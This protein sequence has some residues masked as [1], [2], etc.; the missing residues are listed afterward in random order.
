VPGSAR[1]CAGTAEGIC[2]RGGDWTCRAFDHRTGLGS[3][4]GQDFRTPNGLKRWQLDQKGSRRMKP[5]RQPLPIRRPWW[6]ATLKP[7]RNVQRST[8]RHSEAAFGPP[9]LE[10]APESDRR[11]RYAAQSR[12]VCLS[13]EGVKLSKC[14]GY[15]NGNGAGGRGVTFRQFRELPIVSANTSVHKRFGP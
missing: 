3:A 7:E 11:T 6:A 2:R 1:A 14:R 15:P 5:H 13:G 10:G 4:T 8:R 12:K 9:S